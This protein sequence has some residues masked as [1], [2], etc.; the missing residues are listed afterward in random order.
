MLMFEFLA[1]IS[2]KISAFSKAS[3]AIVSFLDS[4]GNECVEKLELIDF[5]KD[6]KNLLPFG[7]ANSL[8]L[9]NITPQLQRRQACSSFSFPIR[10]VAIF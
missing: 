1:N 3:A 10:F 2:A 8:L 6:Q 5:A 4:G 9:T 7:H